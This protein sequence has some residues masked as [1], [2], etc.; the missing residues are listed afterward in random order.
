MGQV[1]LAD[2]SVPERDGFMPRNT[3]ST[4]RPGADEAGFAFALV[5]FLFSIAPPLIALVVP[6]SFEELTRV[7]GLHRIGSVCSACFSFCVLLVSYGFNRL[8]TVMLCNIIGSTLL[9]IACII[10]STCC[11][12]LIAWIQGHVSLNDLPEGTLVTAALSPV[13]SLSLMTGH[14]LNLRWARQAYSQSSSRRS[15]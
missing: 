1:W 11:S 7:D 6:A 9:A 13:G 2:G 3:S 4:Y 15:V 10:G 14:A 8:R 12:G 5:C